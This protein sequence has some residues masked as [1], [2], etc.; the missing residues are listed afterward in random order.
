MKNFIYIII[1]MICHMG[2]HAQE[3]QTDTLYFSLEESML[4]A[5][6][7]NLNA[8]NARLDVDAADQRVW[9]TAARGLP[10]VNASVDYNYNI[11]LAT[12]LIPD[13]IGNQRIKSNYSLVQ[14]TMQQQVSLEAS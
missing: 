4:Y 14:S 2:L 1:F 11:N 7:N 10:Q 8:E 12:T 3:N 9:E 6:E 13:F 5:M